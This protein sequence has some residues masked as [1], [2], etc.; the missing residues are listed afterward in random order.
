MA[1]YSVIVDE[2]LCDAWLPVAVNFLGMKQTDMSFWETV[3]SWF[4]VQK[5]NE[6]LH[7]HMIH[8]RNTKS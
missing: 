1:T 4:H 5:H 8:D 3:H 6:Y 7:F 2:L